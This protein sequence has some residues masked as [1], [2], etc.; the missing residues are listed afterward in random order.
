MTNNRSWLDALP[1]PLRARAYISGE[2]AAWN[3]GDAVSV[4]DWA[5]RNGFQIVAI[6]VWLATNPGPTIPGPYSW[7][8]SHSEP[9]PSGAPS[10]AAK[11]FVAKFEWH[12]SDSRSRGQEPYFNLTFA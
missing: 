3:R 6:E 4:L 5:N 8:T 9:F 12:P 2:E 11:A 1:Q 10:V 7:E